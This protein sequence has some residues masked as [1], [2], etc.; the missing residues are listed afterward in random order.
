MQ[1]TYE[2]TSDDCDKNQYKLKEIQGLLQET[3]KEVTLKREILLAHA[4]SQQ[5]L[6]ISII[7][8][9]ISA[10]GMIDPLVLKFLY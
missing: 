1:S 6:L 5:V 2:H 9:A 10:M 4:F 3:K 7:C 8:N